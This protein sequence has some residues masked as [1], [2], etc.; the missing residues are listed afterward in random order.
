MLV[1]EQA[2]VA[3]Y[4]AVSEACLGR[5]PVVDTGHLLAGVIA[6]RDTVVRAVW[7]DLGVDPGHLRS[8]LSAG[9]GSTV[10]MRHTLTSRRTAVLAGHA[11]ATRPT[12]FSAGARRVLG[13]AFVLARAHRA[14]RLG[15]GH[16]L[17]AI[18]AQHDDDPA[19]GLL[20][21]LDVD[22][23]ALARAVCVRLTGA[24]DGCLAGH[25][26]RV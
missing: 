7:Q 9:A 22:I 15:P 6:V 20:S 25:T 16:L 19:I 2:R 12:A 8:A 17:L 5:A 14:R 3:V 23:P 1:A 26:P 4:H 10:R 18:A 24:A 11:P 21:A 13:D